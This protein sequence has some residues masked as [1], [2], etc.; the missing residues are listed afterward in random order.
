[1]LEIKVDDCTF[2][3]SHRILDRF[4]ETKLYRMLMGDEIPS[5]F[6]EKRDSHYIIDADPLV[7]TSFVR[8]I[9]GAVLWDEHMNDCNQMSELCILLDVDIKCLKS[10]DIEHTLNNSP[11]DKELNTDGKTCHMDDVYFGENIFDRVPSTS[12][13]IFQKIN[14][15]KVIRSRKIEL[16]TH[17]MQINL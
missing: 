14:K 11:S 10:R 16:D 7:F 6:I 4:A 2:F 9:R 1:M 15:K 17:D 12:N 13:T 3:L 8:L 5:N